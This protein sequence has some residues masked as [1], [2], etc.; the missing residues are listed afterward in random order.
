M[1]EDGVPLCMDETNAWLG[2]PVPSGEVWLDKS[3]TPGIT[4]EI[5]K[6]RT[7]LAN[8]GVISMTLLVNNKQSKLKGKPKLQSKGFS[9]NLKVLDELT[10]L[11]EEALEH[12]KLSSYRN[13]QEIEH[14]LVKTLKK[15]LQ[16]KT[17]LT[18]IFLIH[19][20]EV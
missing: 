12:P 16:S 9:G 10:N 15:H 6:E 8:D 7:S 2:E 19:L 11:A 18:P 14:M 20:T 1:I 17:K 13:I 4:E 3:G 5:M